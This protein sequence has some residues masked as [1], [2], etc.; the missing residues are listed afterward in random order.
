MRMHIIMCVLLM[1]TGIGTASFILL[2]R[3]FNSAHVNGTIERM[4]TCF[5]VDMNSNFDCYWVLTKS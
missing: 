1:F 3:A 2:K 5:S 4:Q